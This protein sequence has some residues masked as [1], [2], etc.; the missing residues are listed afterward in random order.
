MTTPEERSDKA[1]R[2][3]PP[4]WDGGHLAWLW[5]RL[6]DQLV[7]Y[8][9]YRHDPAYRI[10]W[11][12]PLADTD[13]SALDLLESGDAYRGAY[14]A[15]LSY[16]IAE[17][18]PSLAQPTL[19]VVAKPDA[20]VRFVDAY[21]QMPPCVEVSVVPEFADVYTATLEFLRR[22]SL[23][24]AQARP[25][26]PPAGSTL[27][28][29]FIDV[30]DGQLHLRRAQADE[31][32]TLLILHDYGSSAAALEPLLRGIAGRRPLLAPDLPGHGE[33]DR[34]GATAP[35]EI[36]ERLAQA[37]GAI[38]SDAFD[39]AA[40]GA[41]ATLVPALRRRCGARLRRTVLIEPLPAPSGDVRAFARALVPDLTTDAAGSHL[42]RAWLY[43][44]DRALY[45]PWHERSTAAQLALGRPPRPAE[46]QRALIDLLKSRGV[47]AAQ[48]EAALASPDFAA[49]GGHCDALL[50]R[51]GAAIRRSAEAAITL[52][53][54]KFQWGTALLRALEAPAAR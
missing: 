11:S 51:R 2:Y 44:R 42:A 35:E 45:H 7:F 32:R 28:S 46:Q 49:A 21:P 4:Q 24:A 17:D 37:L 10:Q 29:S 8:P 40:V 1:D 34:L 23:P 50:A 13:A 53:D 38:G 30:A 31:G 36:A 27:W 26:A 25:H 16:D 48:L 52:P 14:G 43:L 5:S 3:L 22:Q 19:L 33:S 54:E 6:R 20:L 9:W 12:Q 47:L 39:L 18:L 41:A 15:V